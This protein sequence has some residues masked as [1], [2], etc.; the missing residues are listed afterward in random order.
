MEGVRL[1]QTWRLSS[2]SLT[3]LRR[4]PRKQQADFVI[5]IGERLCFGKIKNTMILTFNMGLKL[6]LLTEIAISS[7]RTGNI[8]MMI[9]NSAFIGEELRIT[10]GIK[11]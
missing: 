2:H 11:D 10:I 8:K 6:F 7:I 4:V 3:R 5:K 9:T 1:L